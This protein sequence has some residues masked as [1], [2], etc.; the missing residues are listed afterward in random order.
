MAAG[1]AMNLL[2]KSLGLVEELAWWRLPSVWALIVS[3]LVSAVVGVTSGWQLGDF[4]LLYWAQSVII[5][6]FQVLK[7]LD[8]EEFSTENF[9]INGRSVSP[10][11]A[12]KRWVAGFF[13]LHY[14]IFHLVYLVFALLFAHSEVVLQTL[15]LAG[16]F[17]LNHLFSYLSNRGSDRRRRPNIGQ[18]MFFPYLRIVPMHLTIV[19]GGFLAGKGEKG[20]LILFLLLKTLADVAMHWQE[21]KRKR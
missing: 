20:A 16:L 19:F 13:A 9:Y 12:T 11:P 1:S 10:T 17:F 14:G 7:I 21:H 2:L 4:M 3:N 8:L 5:G 18:M 15:P 6:F